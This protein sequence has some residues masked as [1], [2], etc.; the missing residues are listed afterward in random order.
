MK[1]QS[2][3]QVEHPPAQLPQLDGDEDD[4]VNDEGDKK[5]EI[6]EEEKLSCHKIMEIIDQAKRERADI[7][8]FFVFLKYQ[9][10]SLMFD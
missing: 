5:K 1:N 7:K 4:H 10:F 9:P 2:V 8:T 3:A 6:T